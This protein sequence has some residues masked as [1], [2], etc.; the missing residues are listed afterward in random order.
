VAAAPE[1]TSSPI[2][3]RWYR[4]DSFIAARNAIGPNACVYVQADST[5]R[6]VRVGKASMG[7]NVR[8][9][10]G[11]GWALEAAMHGTGNLVY[12]AVVPAELCDAIE[13]TLIWTS[14]ESLPYNNQGKLHAP[15]NLV[16]I[17]HSGEVPESW[18]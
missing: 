13:R 9:R 10:G 16:P 12:T 3:L 8:Y 15:S 14:K 2:A 7:L 11:T 1:S 5:G 17:R 4:H 6:P 18:K